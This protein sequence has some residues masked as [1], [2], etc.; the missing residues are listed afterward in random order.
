MAALQSRPPP[1]VVHRDEGGGADSDGAASGDSTSAVVVQ[2]Q[3]EQAADAEQLRQGGV[4]GY[5]S[6]L[7]SY[8]DAMLT[9]LDKPPGYSSSQLNSSRWLPIA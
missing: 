7:V 2:R 5:H 3:G 6:V 1:R 9:C 4:V 8:E